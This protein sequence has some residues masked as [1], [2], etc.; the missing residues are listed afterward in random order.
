MDDSTTAQIDSVI[1]WLTAKEGE[2]WTAADTARVIA[3]TAKIEEAWKD[4][5]K[6]FGCDYRRSKRS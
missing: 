2:T 4:M 5:T 1:P 6:S 3:M